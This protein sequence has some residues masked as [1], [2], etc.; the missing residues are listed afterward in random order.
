[1]AHT[2][3]PSRRLIVAT[4]VVAALTQVG[5]GQSALLHETRR[6]FD[7]LELRPGMTVA[8]IGAGRGEL[9]IELARLIDPQGRTHA[10]DINPERLDDIRAAAARERLAHVIVRADAEDVTNLPDSCCDAIVIRNV[11]HHFSDP[12]SMNRSVA[13]ALEPGGRLAIIDF[14]PTAGPERPVGLPAIREGHGIRPETLTDEVASAGL[15]HVRTIP[16]SARDR[17]PARS[18]AACA[19]HRAVGSPPAGRARIGLLR[20]FAGAGNAAG[21]I[22]GDGGKIA[23]MD[24]SPVSRAPGSG[25]M[26]PRFVVVMAIAGILV[27]RGG[28]TIGMPWG[29]LLVSLVGLATSPLLRPA[30]RF[31]R[32]TL[33]WAARRSRPASRAPRIATSRPTARSSTRTSRRAPPAAARAA[34]GGRARGTG[35]PPRRA[36]R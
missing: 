36:P 18:G 27:F 15:S 33:T 31:G 29:A 10:T 20:V 7:T 6:L 30:V 34:T 35:S 1:M 8:D 14:V 28:E 17:T 11:Y 19:R 24:A 32:W 22:A 26:A 9:T 13:A 3:A 4:S 16:T 25:W 21:W 23:T 5:L 12:S 2:K